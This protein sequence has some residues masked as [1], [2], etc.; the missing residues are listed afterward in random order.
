MVESPEEMRL[1]SGELRDV[2]LMLLRSACRFTVLAVS[3]LCAFSKTS[4][5]PGHDIPFVVHLTQAG[6]L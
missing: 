3:S 5:Y 4:L 6:F 1:E 2:N